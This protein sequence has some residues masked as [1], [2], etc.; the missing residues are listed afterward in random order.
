[1]DLD[2]SLPVIG[3][4]HTSHAELEDTPIQA[5]LNRAEYGTIEIADRYQEGLDGLAEFD[6]AWLM[7][8]LHRLA[9]PGSDPPLRHVPFLLRS[10]QRS[11]GI[12]ATRGPKRINPI[13][14]SLIQILDVTGPII[15]FAGV[16]LVDGTPVIDLKPYVTRFDRPPGEPRC[17]WFDQVTI[18]DGVTP[19]QLDPPRPPA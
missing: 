16:D 15:R 5:G 10:Q 8:W 6:Y 11:R 2:I 13:G 9:G 4:V 18:T 17:G 12:F 3:I 1:M 7:T 14:L 19:R